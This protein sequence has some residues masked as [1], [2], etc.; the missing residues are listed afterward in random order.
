MK[1]VFILI[2]GV[3]VYQLDIDVKAN[4]AIAGEHIAEFVNNP[5]LAL[6]K[7]WSFCRSWWSE[8]PVA[9]SVGQSQ[10]GID[11]ER[12]IRAFEEESKNIETI[13]NPPNSLPFLLNHFE[14]ACAAAV[15]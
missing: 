11:A 2:I 13:R 5:R 9:V 7:L 8:G 4:V 12:E 6:L 1:V 10:D 15:L 14:R 3:L